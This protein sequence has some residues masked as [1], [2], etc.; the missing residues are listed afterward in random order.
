LAVELEGLE[1]S[2]R[3]AKLYRRILSITRSEE[4]VGILSLGKDGL[5]A[6]ASNNDPDNGAAGRKAVSELLFCDGWPELGA[7]SEW[8]RKKRRKARTFPAYTKE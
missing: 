2:I 8:E 4:G 1:I 5:A 6:T 3:I 7:K